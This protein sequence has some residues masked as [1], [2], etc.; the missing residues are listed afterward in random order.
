MSWDLYREMWG[1]HGEFVIDGN[2]K[3][4]EYADRLSTIHVPTLIVV[5]D[6]DECDPV[7][8]QEMNSLIPGSKLAI[9]PKSG[10]LTFVDQN[11]LFLR[12]VDDFL[13]K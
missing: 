9:L 1:S 6:H 12:T 10:H 4:V 7:L 3:S 8:S 2:L 13:H 11:A 5:G